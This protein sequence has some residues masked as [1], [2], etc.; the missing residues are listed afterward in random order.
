MVLGTAQRLH[1]L[2]VVGTGFVDVVGDRGGANEADGFHIGVHQQRVHR[3]LVPLHHI[4]HAVRQSGLLEQIGNEERGRRVE[5][6]GLEHKGVARG[7]RDREHPH[8]HHDRKVEGRDAR[9]HTQRLAHGPVVDAGGHLLGVVALEQLRD[10]SGKLDDLDAPRDL[11]LRIGEHLAVLGGD[12]VRQRV[13]VLVKQLQKFEHDAR[14]A[15]RRRVGPG[16]EGSLCS[17][18][19]FVHFGTVGQVNLACYGACC[20][21]GDLLFAA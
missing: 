13:F 14:P 1:P 6:A 8:G 17:S 20:G 9:H 18:H 21:V 2:A 11:A 3:F 4:E 10:A 12:H 7:N 19:G 15:Q 5:R 16:G